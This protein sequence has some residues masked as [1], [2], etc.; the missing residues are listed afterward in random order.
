MEARNALFTDFAYD[1]RMTVYGDVS[2]RLVELFNLHAGGVGRYSF[3]QG[4]ELTPA[5]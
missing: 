4:L 2:A 3:L 5:V 1:H